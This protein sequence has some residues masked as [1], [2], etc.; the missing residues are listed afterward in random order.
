M[1]LERLSYS[2]HRIQVANTLLPKAVDASLR[3]E[4]I[5]SVRAQREQHLES[6]TVLKLD[7]DVLFTIQKLA[8][9]KQLM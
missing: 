2:R 4:V 3:K 6:I 1:F 8:R 5:E 9:K 7:I